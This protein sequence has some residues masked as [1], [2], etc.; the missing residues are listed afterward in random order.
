MHED[1]NP[2]LADNHQK[3]EK[4]DLE[5]GNLLREDK[6]SLSVQD[7][8]EVGLVRRMAQNQ[9]YDIVYG[10]NAV[11]SIIMS[12]KGKALQFH[13]HVNHPQFQN[14]DKVDL[15]IP[16]SVYTV[17]DDEVKKLSKDLDDGLYD[18]AAKDQEI[19]NLAQNIDP[20]LYPAES[21]I[22]IALD[23]YYEA[24]VDELRVRQMTE[25]NIFSDRSKQDHK[26]TIANT[27]AYITVA[28]AEGPVAQSV[29][30]TC[31]L[32]TSDAADE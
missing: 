12:Y 17:A 3:Q 23:S 29:A 13:G 30:Y 32:Y 26:E 5:D 2:S 18:V 8:V 27:L 20:S 25:A 15:I 22:T 9:G 28:K 11:Q 16:L 24:S 6:L 19:E 31:L 14:E 10:D 21:T 1:D 7:Q 4:I